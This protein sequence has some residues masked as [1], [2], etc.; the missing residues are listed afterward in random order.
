MISA[1]PRSSVDSSLEESTDSIYNKTFWLCYID[2]AALV[3]A[4]VMTFRLANFVHFLKGSDRITGVIMAV[5]LCF[6]IFARLPLGHYIDQWGTR[7]TWIMSTLL[8]LVG[9]FGFMT[10]TELSWFIYA[11]RVLYAIGIAG[12]FTSAIVFIQNQVPAERRTEIIGNLGSSGFLGMIIG[13]LFAD[14]ILYFIPESRNTFLTLF[15]T[16][17]VIGIFYLGI[18]IYLTRGTLHEKPHKSLSLLRL[19]VT[20]W[21]GMVLLVAMTMGVSMAVTGGFLASFVKENGL[22]GIG[23]FFFSYAISAFTFRMLTRHWSRTVGRH[24]MILCGLLGQAIGLFA[25]SFIVSSWQLALPAV[26]CGF[27]HALLF[28]A[29]VSLGSGTFPQQYRGLGTT[30]TLG[31]CELG[32]AIFAPILGTI[33]D[34]VSF[35]AMF[36][37][38]S[39]IALMTAVIY[40]LT[41]AK[42]KDD[43]HLPKQKST[44]VIAEI[45]ESFSQEESFTEEIEEEEEVPTIVESVSIPFPHIGRGP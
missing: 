24:R 45:E 22:I 3:T 27:G 23:P 7:R 20:Y 18:V 28:P 2:N 32:C 37:T 1:V 35:Q 14:L 6:A 42:T 16:V 30:L 29:V 40:Q 38:S 25:L 11:V 33:I 41:A 10:V 12:M 26:A 21:P 39:T 13:S 4:N 34:Y 19:T 44:K 9:S 15:G 43:D 31:F 17:G 36:Y 5:G 8:F